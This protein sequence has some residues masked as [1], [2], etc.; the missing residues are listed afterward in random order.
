M[1]QSRFTLLQATQR[2]EFVQI[3]GS[4]G[5]LAALLLKTKPENSAAHISIC[6]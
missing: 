6:V 3:S 2:Y 4:N 1:V 5:P